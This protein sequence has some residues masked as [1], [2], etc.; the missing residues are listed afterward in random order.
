MYHRTKGPA[1]STALSPIEET[2]MRSPG[3]S[4]RF[5]SAAGRLLAHP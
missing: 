1:R 2:P 4:R 5:G 3:A